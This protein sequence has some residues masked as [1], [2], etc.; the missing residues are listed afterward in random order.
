MVRQHHATGTD[1]DAAGH[2]GDLPDHEIGRRARHRSE[3]VVLGQPVADIA[4]RIRMAR[5][6]DAVAQR[7]GGLGA[8]RDDGEVEDRE[9]NHE[10]NLVRQI[11]PTKGRGAQIRRASVSGADNYLPKVG[12]DIKIRYI[13][14]YMLPT[15]DW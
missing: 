9:R 4:Q 14:Y 10:I 8:G 13:A 3:I 5:Q 12:W 2:R 6:I 15:I 11:G 7:R 1:P